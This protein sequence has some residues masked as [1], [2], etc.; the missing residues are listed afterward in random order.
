MNAIRDENDYC[1]PLD[2]YKEIKKRGYEIIKV[3]KS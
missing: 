3:K 2:L 1:T